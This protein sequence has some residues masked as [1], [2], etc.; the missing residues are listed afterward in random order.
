MGDVPAGRRARMLV[1][2]HHHT[3]GINVNWTRSIRGETRTPVTPCG[4]G[5]RSNRLEG[6]TG[7]DG[8]AEP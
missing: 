8:G 6:S 7:K 3:H 4:E 1:M 5:L 2:R